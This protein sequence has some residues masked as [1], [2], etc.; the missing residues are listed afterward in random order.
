M[1]KSVKENVQE[2][3]TTLNE[4]LDDA[5]KFSDKGN[6]AAGTRVRKALLEVSKACKEIRQQVSDE[7]N[8]E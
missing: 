4:A 1:S 7:K 3:V 2:L 6:K 8:A 5:E